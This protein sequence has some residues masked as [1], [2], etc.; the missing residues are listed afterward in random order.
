M[1]HS[2]KPRLVVKLQKN[3]IK[4][5]SALSLSLEPKILFKF[6]S[7]NMVSPLNPYSAS[8][9]IHL[10]EVHLP[11]GLNYRFAS[12]NKILANCNSDIITYLPELHR[13][14]IVEFRMNAPSSVDFE[15][16]FGPH[17][18]SRQIYKSKLF[19]FIEITLINKT[20]AYSLTSSPALFLPESNPSTDSR[21]HAQLLTHP[22]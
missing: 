16:G 2:P 3:T 14:V 15:A 5:P 12:G 18:C 4:I 1:S 7:T 22:R 21:S 17:P 8:R 6:I 11:N 9:R 19:V 10:G 13:V 20:I